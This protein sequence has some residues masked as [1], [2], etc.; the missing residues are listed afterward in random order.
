MEIE[1]RL[2]KSSEIEILTDLS[3]RSKRSNG[4]DD[5]FME[6]CREELTVT[7][8]R[9]KAG[10][11]WVAEADIICGCVCLAPDVTE[12][13]GEIHAYF[14]DPNWQRRGI[15]RLLWMKIL[16]RAV[17]LGLRKLYLDA[18]PASVPFY[19]AIGFEIVGENPSGSIPGRTLPHMSIDLKPL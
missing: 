8:E 15:G 6:A 7:D 19:Q 18:D 11:Y 14:I 3:M 9:M 5:L 1:I 12:K 17:H 2:A 13:S 4:Y 10:E 16:E